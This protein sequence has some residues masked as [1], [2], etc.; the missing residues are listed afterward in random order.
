MRAAEKHQPFEALKTPGFKPFV[1]TF[2]QFKTIY[3]TVE[4]PIAFVALFFEV[5]LK[6]LDLFADGVHEEKFFSFKFLTFEQREE[7][8]ERNTAHIL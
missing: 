7:F 5:I 2:L 6:P 4:E 3:A 8:V 1:A